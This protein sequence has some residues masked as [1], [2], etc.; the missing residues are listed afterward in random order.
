MSDELEPASDEVEPA[1]DEA[2]PAEVADSGASPGDVI[3][4]H[5]NGS[6]TYHP[7]GSTEYPRCLT[8]DGVRYE[9]SRD[10]GGVVVYTEPD[11]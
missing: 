7:H 5:K 4:E 6:R 3:L 8:L 1:S 2:A 11:Y 10:E 9:R